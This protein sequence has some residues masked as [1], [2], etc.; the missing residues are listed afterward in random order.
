VDP[1]KR[2]Q[3][4]TWEQYQAMTPAFA[5]PTIEDFMSYNA[6]QRKVRTAEKKS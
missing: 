5:V 1:L 4:V 2:G 3:Q 6:E